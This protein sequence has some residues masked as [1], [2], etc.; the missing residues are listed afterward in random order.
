MLTFPF[1]PQTKHAQRHQRGV[2]LIVVLILMSALFLV[3]AFGAR[4]SLLGEKTSR[5]DRDRQIAFQAAEAA[6][7]DAEIDLMGPNTAANS[8]VCDT[9]SKQTGLFVEG[10][11]L[12]STNRGLCTSSAT[13]PLYK[14]VNFEN[15]DDSTRQYV[16]LGEF[17]G[18]RET[19]FATATS[20]LPAQ[21]PRYII[22]VI[23]YPRPRSTNETAFLITAM[24]Y[25]LSQKTQVMLQSVVYKP[26]TPGC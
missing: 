19:G 4:L 26:V 15:T 7:S 10:C 5:N 3:V 14:S 12:T 16:K 6:L 18:G 13:T 22:E 20:A 25:G 11:G 23:Q 8:R 21:M 17:T 1:P 24:G 2:S 9:S